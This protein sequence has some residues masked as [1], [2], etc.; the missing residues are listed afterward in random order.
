MKHHIAQYD[1]Q[2]EINLY[3]V[4]TSTLLK[5]Q[6]APTEKVISDLFRMPK[7]FGA[8]VSLW[9]KSPEPKGNCDYYAV[10]MT[11]AKRRFCLWKRASSFLKHEK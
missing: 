6:A 10:A 5:N 2:F 7:M 1:S 4:L 11:M 9:H 3:L 8:F